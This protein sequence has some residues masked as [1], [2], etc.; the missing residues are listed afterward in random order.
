MKVAFVEPHLK[1]FGGIRRI[2]ELSNRLT[3]RGIEVTVFHPEGTPCEWMECRAQVQPSER[4]LDTSLD[5]VIYNDPNPDDFRWVQRAQARLKVFYVLE[6]YET[7]GVA[8]PRS[9]VG[10]GPLRRT[11]F[12]LGSVVTAL[13]ILFPKLGRHRDMALSGKGPGLQ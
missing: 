10:I 3:A 12:L 2:L 7:T 5:V 11:V 13:S 4:L 1:L 6:L 9:G 8:N